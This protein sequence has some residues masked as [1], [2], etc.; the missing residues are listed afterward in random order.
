M[1]RGKINV[2]KLNNIHEEKAEVIKETSEENSGKVASVAKDAAVVEIL[3]KAAESNLVKD[4]VEAA[5]E[6]GDFAGTFAKA[7]PPVELSAADFAQPEAPKSLFAGFDNAG[8][9]DTSF[10][11]S[12]SGFEEIDWGSKFDGGFGG[13]FKSL[14]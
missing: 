6:G 2:T 14:W 3:N 13:N 9:G 8:F 10:G 12:D 4:L 1:T 11:G 5:K 7:D